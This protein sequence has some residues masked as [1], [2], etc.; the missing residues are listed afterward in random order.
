MPNLPRGD[1]SLNYLQMYGGSARSIAEAH[2]NPE[3]FRITESP[4]STDSFNSFEYLA[5]RMRLW[6]GSDTFRE[7]TENERFQVHYNQ[8]KRTFNRLVDCNDDRKMRMED[9]AMQIIER[10]LQ[11]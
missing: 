5:R 4:V 2:S 9:L 3:P 7:P 6:D 10:G 8:E 1:I 11:L